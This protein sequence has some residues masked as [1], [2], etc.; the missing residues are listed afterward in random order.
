[1]PPAPAKI[2]LLVNPTAASGR[3]AK[4]TA[5]VAD[6][7]R[8]SG[9]HVRVLAGADAGDATRRACQAVEE[10]ADAL[11]ALGGDG[12]VN[13]A[14]QAVAGTPVPLGIVPAGSGND[15]ARGL[16]LPLR[17]PLA[18]AG[19][20]ASGRTRAVD[21]V[22]CTYGNEARWYAG[23]LGAGFDS[24]VNERANRMRWPR[25]RQRYNVAILAELRVFKALPFT[26]TLDGTTIETKAMLV[27]VGNATS[28]GGGM[29][30]CPSASMDDGLLEVTVVGPVSTPEFIRVFP[31]VYRGTHVAHR[32]ITAVRATEVRLDSPGVVAYADGE[33]FGDLPVTCTIMPG[34]LAVLGAGGT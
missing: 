12:L 6:R 17:D 24:Q 28:Y 30:V 15:I 11:V 4:A 29:R 14:L 32:A 22:R 31:K 2:A 21:A 25:G 9:A 26:L 18:A 33:R 1:M 16:G 20:V 5:P 3:A 27:A 10:G 7:L 19:L 34:A 23:V 13:L 8:A